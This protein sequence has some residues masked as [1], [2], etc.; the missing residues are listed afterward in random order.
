MYGILAKR[1]G[2]DMKRIILTLA[3]ALGVGAAVIVG[4]S[5]VHAGD[6]PGQSLLRIEAEQT[7]NN[8][9]Y[10]AGESVTVDGT[11]RGDVYCAAQSV[12]VTGAIEG[13]LICAA[14]QIEFRDNATVA[15]NV[16]VAAQTVRFSDTTEIGKNVSVFGQTV[17]IDKNAVINGDLNGASESVTVNGTVGRDIAFGLTQLTVNGTVGRNIDVELEHLMLAEH[18]TVGGDLRYSAATES[19]LP[20]NVVAGEIVYTEQAASTTSGPSRAV[21]FLYGAVVLILLGLTL[22]LVVPRF[23]QNATPIRGTRLGT[24]LLV[25]ISALIV[26]PI[27]A[28][29]LIAS[30]VLWPVGIAILLVWALA[31][32]VAIPLS[33]FMIGRIILQKRH[34]N[35]I[36]TML[37]GTGVVA[38]LCLIPILNI[39]V[40][41]LTM[42][43]GTGLALIQ[44][45]SS[46]S[47]PVYSVAPRKTTTAKTRKK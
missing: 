2:G 10:G 15:G 36:L 11:V 18:A 33:A 41:V 40:I 38:L 42:A 14:Q 31:A 45:T 16:R 9:W 28:V 37:L 43:T 34:S 47:K 24:G 19:T 3:L 35:I 25:G 13:D 44:A 1:I 22:A 32:I 46:L 21:S 29:L 4:A 7:V 6:G 30:L 27:I 39:I 17:A 23:V 20:Q 12:I 8:S 5:V 26:M